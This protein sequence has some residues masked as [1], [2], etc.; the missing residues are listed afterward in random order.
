MEWKIYDNITRMNYRVLGLEDINGKQGCTFNVHRKMWKPNLGLGST[1]GFG[2]LQ[3][4]CLHYDPT[5]YEEYD[6]CGFDRYAII[7]VFFSII[8]G[9]SVVH[10]ILL[11]FILLSVCRLQSIVKGW[12]SWLMDSVVG[13]SIPIRVSLLCTGE[14]L[15]PPFA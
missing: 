7:L 6:F 4:G 15:F 1:M 3:L 8:C 9:F 14:N 12:D 13:K 5:Q 10:C 11:M 2:H